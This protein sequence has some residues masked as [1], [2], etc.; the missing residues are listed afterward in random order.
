MSKKGREQNL[1][2]QEKAQAAMKKS[3]GGIFKKNLFVIAMVTVAALIVG[4]AWF[5]AQKNA[6][7]YSDKLVAPASATEDFGVVYAPED[8]G[9]EGEVKDATEVVLYE[10]FQCPAC[11]AFESIASDTLDSLVE[12]GKITVEYRPVAFLDDMGAS[13]ND[14]G[15]RA[16]NVALAVRDAE[17]MKAFDEFHDYLYQNQPTEGGPG[18]SDRE[19]LEAA[20]KI[21]PS[22]DER[23]VLDR[24]YVPWIVEATE[25]FSAN[26]DISSTPTILIDGEQVDTGAAVAELEKLLAN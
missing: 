6:P 15:R 21:A 23:A 24:K 7:N 19:L 25:A 22:V 2:R 11:Q 13:T 10:D 17:G 9:F 26:P 8:A 1:S 20:Q 16:A 12:E 14:Y 18:P 3:E 5:A 4:G